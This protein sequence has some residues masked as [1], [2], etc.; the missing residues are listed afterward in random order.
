VVIEF[1]SKDADHI[2]PILPNTGLSFKQSAFNKKDSPFLTI[3]YKNIDPGSMREFE[4]FY[5]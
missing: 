5:R 4:L 1:I 2:Y 3:K